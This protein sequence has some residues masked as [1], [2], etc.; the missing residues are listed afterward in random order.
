MVGRCVDNDC[1][2]QISPSSFWMSTAPAAVEK[3]W[4]LSLSTLNL[5]SERILGKRWDQIDGPRGQCLT[6]MVWKSGR[7]GPIGNSG[8]GE[9]DNVLFNWRNGRS[10]RDIPRRRGRRIDIDLPFAPWP[11]VDYVR[12]CRW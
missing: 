6:I 2:G 4:I 9:K 12:V 3:I 8:G 5:I 10:F 11:V 7:R 1:L